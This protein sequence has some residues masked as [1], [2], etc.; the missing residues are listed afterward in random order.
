[1]GRRSGRRLKRIGLFGGSFDPPHRAHVALAHAALDALALDAVWWIPAGDPWQKARAITPAVHR[2]AMVQAA[3]ADEP[4]FRL[5]RCELQRQG[6]SY[7]LD[8]VDEL[9]ARHPH[10]RWV[11][12]IGQDQYAGLHTWRGWQALL[13]KVELAVANR[14]GAALAVDAAVAATPHRAVPLPMLDVSSTEIRRRAAA[15]EP[16]GDLVPPA[17]QRYIDH[18]HLYRKDA[19]AH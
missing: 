17:V 5:E 13:A 18:H 2:E 3:I 6:P 11:L 16:L 19:A 9:Q 1:M 14:P 4:R 8:T 15:G 10:T 7:T 12:I